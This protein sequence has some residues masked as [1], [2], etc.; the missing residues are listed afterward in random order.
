MKAILLSVS[1]DQ[2]GIV[3][4]I[5]HFVGSH[6]GNITNTSQHEDGGVFI[7]RVEFELE[8]FDITKK[9]IPVEFEKVA[10]Q[11]KARFEIFFSDQI[12]K[13][14]IMASKEDHCLIDLI[15]RQK[16]GEL[17]MK[18]ACVISNHDELRKISEKENIPFFFIPIIENDPTYE[19][20]QLDIIKKAKVEIIVLAKYMRILS[21]NFL[22]KVGVPII[23]IHH[24]FLPDFAG[25]NPYK[26]AYL[27]GVKMLGATAHYVTDELDGGPIIEQGVTK[28][29]HT[30]NLVDFIRKGRDTEK[31]VLSNALRLHLNHRV[32]MYNNKT[33]IFY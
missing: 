16:T 2:K 11:I 20:K 30:D 24:S 28:V 26:R 31:T 27:R 4:K 3:E 23:N 1:P 7:S 9:N 19:K 8:N 5:A 14:C 21:P 25:A 15:L 18:I 10:K 29:T 17:N 33:A 32:I 12:P 22:K 6:G 13:V